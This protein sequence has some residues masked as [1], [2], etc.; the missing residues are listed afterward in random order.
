[1]AGLQERVYLR[2]PGPAVERPAAQQ[3]DRRAAPVVL[4]VEAD[5]GGVFLADGDE[6]H[7]GVLPGC[8]DARDGGCALRAAPR[9][10]LDLDLASTSRLGKPANPGKTPVS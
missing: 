8:G 4:L 6:R 10:R 7:G 5:V 3:D 9:R 2:L 1:M